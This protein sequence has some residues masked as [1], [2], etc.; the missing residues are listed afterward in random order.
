MVQ[1]SHVKRYFSDLI[2]RGHLVDHIRLT[3]FNS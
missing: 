3:G 2:Q 1:T